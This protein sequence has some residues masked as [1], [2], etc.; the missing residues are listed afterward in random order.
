[1]IISRKQ[2]KIASVSIKFEWEVAYAVSNGFVTFVA[3]DLG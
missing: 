3:D 2:Y 1:M